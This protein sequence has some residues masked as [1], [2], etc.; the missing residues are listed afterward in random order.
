MRRQPPVISNITPAPGEQDVDGDAIITFDVTDTGA[1]VDTSTLV[2]GVKING[3]DV[4]GAVV[5]TAI[6]NNGQA[7]TLKIAKAVRLRDIVLFPYW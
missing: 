6:A 5:T 2:V 4:T 3:A 1:G 7:R